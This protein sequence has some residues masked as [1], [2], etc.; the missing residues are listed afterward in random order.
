MSP[1]EIGQGLA[2]PYA[3]T[4]LHGKGGAA[5]ALLM[6]FMAV[7]SAS[8]AELIACSSI[9]TYDV[10]R[11]YINPRASGKQLVRVSHICVIGFG[12]FMGAFATMFTYIGVTIGW[13]MTFIGIILCPPVFALA[14]T[15]FTSRMNKLAMI[16]GPPLGMI[17]GLASWLGSAAAF[18]NGVINTTTLTGIYP[19]LIGNCCSLV[20]FHEMTLL[21]TVFSS[22][23]H[24]DS[25]I[26]STNRV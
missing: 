1:Y 17:T 7:T 21:K 10:Y 12:I 8:S 25:I 14:G 9:L 3:L 24:D 13:M 6:T 26:H 5:A 15:L 2:V 4:A 20:Y 22:P 19:T 23:I 11:T 18:N 16:F